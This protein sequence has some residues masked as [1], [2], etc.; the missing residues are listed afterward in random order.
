MLRNFPFFRVFAPDT[1]AAVGAL[2]GLLITSLTSYQ[3]KLIQ[4]SACQPPAAIG[5]V[6]MPILPDVSSQRQ[7]LPSWGQCVYK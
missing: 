3:C 7:K 6:P 1:A 2:P 5:S 4:T